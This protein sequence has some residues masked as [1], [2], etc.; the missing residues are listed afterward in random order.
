[1][2]DILSTEMASGGMVEIPKELIKEFKLKKGD[3]FVV[4]SENDSIILKIIHPPAPGE[5]MDLVKK[6]RSFARKA[7]IT[8]KD[9]KET[10][11]AVRAEARAKDHKKK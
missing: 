8:K 1:M 5:F 4:L 7:G 6:M 10:I 11:V 9:L 2:K 3:K